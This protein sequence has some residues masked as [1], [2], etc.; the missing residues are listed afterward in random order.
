MT[1]TT[2]SIKFA[3]LE[4]ALLNLITIKNDS[5]N[6]MRNISTTLKLT[7]DCTILVFNLFEFNILVLEIE[8]ITHVR[9]LKDM[10]YC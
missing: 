8:V 4:V 9:L 6:S 1:N 2:I 3:I 10:L 7:I 5:G